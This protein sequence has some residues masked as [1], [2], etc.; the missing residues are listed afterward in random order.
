MKLV[1]SIASSGTCQTPERLL[2]TA[3]EIFAELG[4]RRATV[5]DIC[6][7]AETN[8]AS[9]NYHFGDKLG[10]Y[11]AVLKHWL[12]VA[13]EKY[14][15]DMGLPASASPQQ[16]LFAFIHS[17]LLRLLGEGKPAWHGR[18]MAREMIEPTEALDA[19]LVSTIQPLAA[20]LG[21]IVRDLLGAEAD[22]ETI[23]FCS[24]SIAGQCCFYRHAEAMLERL[25]PKH[26]LDAAGI[27]RLAQHITDFS[28]A[29]LQGRRK[30]LAGTKPAGTSW[31]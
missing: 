17:F 5:R 28:L 18:L 3:G 29:G 21:S 23:R 20:K 26:K 1:E 22:E 24:N 25:Y 6:A 10:L 12:Q 8:V 11:T 7:R 14:P 31:R 19:V 9:V 16:R 30:A 27:E 4:F 15:I 2:E 13:L